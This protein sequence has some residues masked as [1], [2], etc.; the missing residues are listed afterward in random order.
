MKWTDFLSDGDHTAAEDSDHRLRLMQ[1]AAAGGVPSE[2]DTG[3]PSAL[4]ASSRL[5]RGSAVDIAVFTVLYL[6]NCTE[7]FNVSRLL[8]DRKGNKRRESGRRR[9]TV[10]IQNL[11]RKSGAARNGL[12]RTRG[13]GLSLAESDFVRAQ[14]F[15]Y[16]NGQPS[17]QL[18]RPW[19]SY[20]ND[21]GLP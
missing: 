18:G 7:T 3:Q 11:P 21:A 12:G 1:L 8:L 4:E 15:N 5:E 17:L 14:I 2:V 13:S 16:G 9:G 19:L 6:G 20:L 10:C